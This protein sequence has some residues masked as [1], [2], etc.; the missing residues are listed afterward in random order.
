MRSLSR[1]FHSNTIAGCS[2]MTMNSYPAQCQRNPTSNRSALAL[3]VWFRSI[4][5]CAALAW[6]FFTF[7]HPAASGELKAA[8]QMMLVAYPATM[9][10]D[11]VDDYF[12]QKVADPY[13]WLENDV[14]TDGQVAAWVAAQSKFTTDYLATLP[15]RDIFKA[16][17]K[18]LSTYER[19]SIPLKKANRTFYQRTTGEQNQRMLYV[20][21]TANGKERVLIDPNIWSK[22][23]A[24][25]LAEWSASEDGTLLA[26]AVQ[27]GGTDWRTIH[28]LNVNTGKVLGDE[29]KWARFT[30]IAWAKD[31]VGFFYNRFPEPKHGAAPQA[32]V[33][34]HA[35]YFHALGAPQAKDR[36]VYATPDKP[37]LLHSFTLTSDGHYLG[38]ISSPGSL[39]T[40][41]TVVDLKSADWKPRRLV[42]NFNDQWSVIDSVGTKFFL[43]TTKEAP[44]LKVV[45]MD[46]ADVNP[47]I[48]DLVP[49]QDAVLSG[50]WM[51]GERLLLSYQVDAAI[52]IRRHTLEGKADGVVKLPGIGTAVGFD[53]GL[54]DKETFFGYTSYNAPGI[55]YRYD[56]ANNV[57]KVWSEAKVASDLNQIVVERR[58][59]NSKD[60]TRI[61][62]FIVR[63]KDVIGPA[64]TLLYAYGGFAISEPPAFSSE[65]LAWVEQGG[66]FVEAHIRGGGEYGKPWND[67]GRRQNKQNV[68]DD[69]IAAGEY[70]KAHGITSKDGLAIQGASNGGLLIG[71]VVNQ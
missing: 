60:G 12:G 10:D 48:V 34:N 25:A 13:R 26:Y 43:L 23:G 8:N 20:R 5:L 41:L 21:D 52:E 17:L 30:T 4:S 29:I 51:V 53:G 27:D 15:G 69:F 58:F 37:I 35:I 65:R 56:V 50:A 11:V 71:A 61:P 19:F 32:G 6:Q 49:E 55:I 33:G 14:R 70:L 54:D 42:D 59:Y 64:P 46:I 36:L 24:T 40:D 18:Q 68:F 9:K 2:M 57:A 47:V 7:A 3:R 31:G 39:V 62:M 22:D 1:W 66:V 28:V 44:R 16:R 38:I 63:R 67:A 45:T